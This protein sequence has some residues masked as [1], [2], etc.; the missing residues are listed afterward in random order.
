MPLPGLT[1]IGETINDSVPSTK[2][3]FDA[4][5]IAGI[6]DIA[7][8]QDE[9]GA[10]YID[11]NIGPRPAEFMAEM[12]AKIQAVT[13]KPLSIDTPDPAL[14]EAGLKAYDPDRAGGKKPIINSISALRAEMF[15]LY[16]IRPFKPILLVSEN[17]VEGRSKPCHT[18]EETY[19]AAQHLVKMFFA[20]CPGA[21][22]DDCIID[23][24][25]AALGQRFGGQ[26]PPVGR[27]DG[28]DPPGPQFRR[29]SRFG[30]PEQ[31][32][33]DAA[34]EAARRL[35]GQRSVGERVPHQGRCPLGWTW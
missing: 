17:V 24:G 11:A 26:Y 20:R 31:L 4:G 22:N 30:G 13:A 5:D 21:T 2:K 16:K 18:A 28:T 32:H 33:G 12:V 1:I 34:V 25:I 27:G 14:A 19:A 29:L 7:R 10:G 6:L 15:D 8:M 3:L 35:A 9:K 23:P